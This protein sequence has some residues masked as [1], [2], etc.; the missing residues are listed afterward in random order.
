MA[1]AFAPSRIFIKGKE[2]AQAINK[3][4]FHYTGYICGWAVYITAALTSLKI[5][6]IKS[7]TKTNKQKTFHANFP[8]KSMVT[9]YQLSFLYIHWKGLFVVTI[10]RNRKIRKHNTYIYMIQ[11]SWFFWFLFLFCFWGVYYDLI[12]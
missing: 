9:V 7:K 5:F 1:W 11:G 2:P 6:P 10:I 12:K 3:T 4:S 8:C